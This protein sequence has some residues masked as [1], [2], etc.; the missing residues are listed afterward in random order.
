VSLTAQLTTSR[1]KEAILERRAAELQ[2]HCQ[3]FLLP[4]NSMNKSINRLTAVEPC[5][6]DTEYANCLSPDTIQ[7][8]DENNQ[9]QEWSV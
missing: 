1:S 9:S 8:R 7:T 3:P 2:V 5:A 4:I 6:A